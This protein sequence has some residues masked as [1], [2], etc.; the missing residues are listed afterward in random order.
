M[1]AVTIRPARADD[2]PR[3]RELERMIVEASLPIIGEVRSNMSANDAV[4]ASV[5]DSL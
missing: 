4:G 5:N 1:T 3:I 2:A